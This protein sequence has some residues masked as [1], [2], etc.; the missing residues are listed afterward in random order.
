MAFF[1]VIHS[2]AMV[3]DVH[4]HL[5]TDDIRRSYFRK[6]KGRVDKAVILHYPTLLAHDVTQQR[7]LPLD[8][9]LALAEHR[10]ELLV[11]GSVTME[12]DITPQLATLGRLLS[13]QK[14]AGIKLYIG[15]QHFYPTDERVE[16]AARLCA[17]HNRPLIFHTGDVYDPNGIALLKY[18]HPLAIDE[19]AAR[20]PETKIIVAH[21]GFPYLLETAM[22]AGKNPN[23]YVDI[24]GTVDGSRED[25]D[26]PEEVEAMTSQYIEDLRRVYAYF[27]ELRF[28]TLFGTDYGGEDTDLRLVDPYFKVV[29]ALFVGAA[30]E[31]VEGGLAVRLFGIV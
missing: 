13:E 9:L 11:V 4:T 20:Y 8:E 19:V 3:V 24:S 31:S 14:I 26:D 16:H 6:A 12:S 25:G 22:M 29:D 21:F 17:Q 1:P 27:P 23:V 18:S 2:K 28:K 15:Y 10:P 30:K 5:F 7:P